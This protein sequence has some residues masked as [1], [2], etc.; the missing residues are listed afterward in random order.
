MATDEHSGDMV[1]FITLLNCLVPKTDFAMAI[2]EMLGQRL[3][4]RASPILLAPTSSNT[5]VKTKPN[6]N[7]AS[8]VNIP[9]DI[10]QQVVNTTKSDGKVKVQPDEKAQSH[11]RPSTQ[12]PATT[13]EVPVSAPMP[14]PPHRGTSQMPAAEPQKSARSKTKPNLDDLILPFATLPENT[15]TMLIH[16]T[17][18]AA[19]RV[20]KDSSLKWSAPTPD[21][22]IST[23]NAERSAYVVRLILAFLNRKN[24]QNM[25]HGRGKRW[26]DVKSHYPQ[27]A[28]EKVCWDIVKEIQQDC[29]LTFEERMQYLIKLLCFYKSKCED[30]LKGAQSEEIGPC[31]SPQQGREA[32]AAEAAQDAQEEKNAQADSVADDGDDLQNSGEE[33][34]A[35]EAGSNGA[36]GDITIHDA[37]VSVVQ[38]NEVNFT[39]TAPSLN[40]SELARRTLKR[41]STDTTD[42]ECVTD[43]AESETKRVRVE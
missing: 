17:H 3:Q 36:E 1:E 16:Q 8:V 23:A 11:S 32:N 14:S 37:D 22:S 7:V 35:A 10:N 29:K 38:T 26:E 25:G 34:A 24:L 43:T 15:T 42:V 18:D 41:G 28:V 6:C 27:D 33:T 40:S 4:S 12:K 2:E 9:I 13:Q 5:S 20:V 21:P 31:H 30:F 39:A 19:L